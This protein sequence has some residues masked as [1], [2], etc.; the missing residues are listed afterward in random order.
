MKKKL[1]IEIFNKLLKYRPE[2]SKYL[3][4]IESSNEE[5]LQE[6]F[7]ILQKYINKIHDTKLKAKFQNTLDKINKIHEKEKLSKIEEEKEIEEI[8][9]SLQNIDA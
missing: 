9:L 2:L 8:L 4:I 1:I 3:P 5:E 6:I 7:T